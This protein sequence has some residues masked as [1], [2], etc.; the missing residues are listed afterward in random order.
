MAIYRSEKLEQELQKLTNRL[1]SIQDTVVV[2]ID[3]FVVAAHTPE[4][5]TGRKANSPQIAAMTAA[6]A[7]LG[8]QTLMQ[9]AQGGLN[10]LLI[11]GDD[12][13]LVVHPVNK[14]AAIAA[15]V[16]KGAKMGIVMNEIRRTS[17]VVHDILTNR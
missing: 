17:E 5:L 1:E 9:M 10:R 7:G 6:L 13:A 4:D 16:S 15:I 3:G 2:S 8:E 11:E 12:G 14:T